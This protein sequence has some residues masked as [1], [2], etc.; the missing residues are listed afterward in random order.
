LTV[1]SAACYGSAEFIASREEHTAGSL[2]VVTLGK[3]AAG[4][5]FLGA[6]AAAL[7]GE[8][9]RATQSDTAL[10]EIGVVRQ[11]V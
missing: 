11:D 4:L 1:A 2:F 9:R 6:G 3:T 5:L 7:T 8:R 10:S